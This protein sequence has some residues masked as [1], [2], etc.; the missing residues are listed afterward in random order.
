MAAL[1][2]GR[3]SSDVGFFFRNHNLEAI[4][5]LLVEVI[6]IIEQQSIVGLIFL[7]VVLIIQNIGCIIGSLSSSRFCYSPPIGLKGPWKARRTRLLHG[8][9]DEDHLTFR[10]DDR[11]VVEIVER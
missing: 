10:A 6:L 3:V 5:F 11:I 2:K 4:C 8:R 1:K 7:I 9:N